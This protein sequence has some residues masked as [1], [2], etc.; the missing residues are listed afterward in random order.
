MEHTYESLRKKKINELRQIA[1]GISHEAVQGATQMNKDHLLH[2]LCTAL[3]IDMHVH[4]VAHVKGK[5]K[6][7]NEIKALKAR[8][9]KA[10][11]AKDSAELQFCLR[12]IHDLKRELRKAAE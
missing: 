12:K 1:A 6:V 7:K 9:D 3:N 10:L 4:H 5:T 2:A 8:R 11:A